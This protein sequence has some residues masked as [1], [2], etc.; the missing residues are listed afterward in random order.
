MRRR[1]GELVAVGG[2]RRGV[3]RAQRRGN[4]GA[5]PRACRGARGAR[6]DG[7]VDDAGRLSRRARRRARWHG[8][9]VGR[10]S[11]AGC[12]P[13]I[14]VACGTHGSAGR[15]HREAE[16]DAGRRP[17][18]AQS[19]A[20][21]QGPRAVPFGARRLRD[22]TVRRVGP[23]AVRHG[24]GRRRARVRQH[25]HRRSREGVRLRRVG[26][27]RAR[28]VPV[29]EGR[30]SSRRPSRTSQPEEPAAGCGRCALRPVATRRS[31]RQRRRC[32][33]ICSFALAKRASAGP[34]RRADR[35]APRRC[36]GSCVGWSV[37]AIRVGRSAARCGL[38]LP[39]DRP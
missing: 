13:S 21:G 31:P 29:L 17:L 37:N 35:S 25:H 24:P 36:S 19:H 32:R 20:V 1:V 3:A 6:R 33:C 16:C 30:A 2:H 18:R 15:R 5:R 23:A 22:V 7:H 12:R 11:R 34:P 9:V 14:A 27:H 39:P 4:P 28:H 10:R 26:R 8:D 38:A